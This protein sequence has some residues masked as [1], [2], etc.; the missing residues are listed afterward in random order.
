MK[1][2]NR[3]T[4][5]IKIDTF[6]STM[7]CLND[8]IVSDSHLVRIPELNGYKWIRVSQHPEAIKLDTYN[9]PYLYCLSTKKKEIEINNRARSAKLRFAIRSNI[10]FQYPQELVNKFK[11]YLEL[12][13]ANV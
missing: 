5:K 9:E 8:V 10:D 1:N 3:V 2:N 7:Y 13:S 12:E 11:N 6:G 4:A